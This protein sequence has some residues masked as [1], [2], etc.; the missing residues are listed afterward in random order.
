MRTTSKKGQ[1]L[2]LTAGQLAKLGVEI[3]GIVHHVQD[4]HSSLTLRCTKCGTEWSH[5]L[6]TGGRLPPDYWKC[7]NG[8]NAAK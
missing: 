2:R 5:N 4:Q 1:P 3:V 6:I 8:C 7:P